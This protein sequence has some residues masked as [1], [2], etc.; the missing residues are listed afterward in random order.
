MR[1]WKEIQKMLRKEFLEIIYI[2]CNMRKNI[3]MPAKV[4]LYKVNQI[5]RTIFTILTLTLY[6]APCPAGTDSDATT[7]TAVKPMAIEAGRLPNPIFTDNSAEVCMNSRYSQHSLNGTAN[8]QQISNILWAAGKA[9]F[10]GTH[11]NIYL[12]TPT[13]T[14]SYDPNGHSLSWYSNEV[15]NDGAFVI[16]YDCQ[17]DFD[18]GV[19]FMPALLASVSLWNSAE[20]AVSSCPKGIGYSKARLIFGVQPVKGLTTKLAVQSSISEGEPGWLPDPCT[21]GDKGLEDVLANLKYVSNFA[22][23]NLT[24]RQISQILWSGYGCTD[25]TASGKAGLTVPS[26]WASYY[27]TRSIYLANENGVFRY[28][29]RNPDT[30]MAS[31]DHR[32]E[33]IDSSSAG[34]G[35]TRPADSRSRLQSTVSGLP[36]APCYVILCLD[37]SSV[38]Q[39]YARLEVGFAAGNML[40][41]ATAID[42]GCYFNAGLTPAEQAGIQVATN[43]PSSH[44]PHAIVSIGPIE[45]TVSISVALQG[46]G[47]SNAGWAVPLI[48]KFFTPGADV[49]TDIPA[50]EFKLTTE[51]S[52]AEKMAV[53]EFTGVAPGIYDITIIGEATLMNIKRSVVI[54][55]PNTSI[56]MGTLLEGDINNDNRIDFKDFVILSTSWL[57][58]KSLP[59]YDI[60]SDFD[61]DGLVNAAD[62]SLLAS[63][64]L[65]SSP[66]EIIP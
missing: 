43:I 23:T 34:R 6:V 25:H 33:Q 31:R 30:N 2:I 26:A 47:R 35:S 12:A 55:A 36:Q 54:S 37:S 61:R 38:S 7:N 19:S 27:L 21:A 28:H 51:K 46:E 59:A 16:F 14:Y 17:H 18:A 22:Q 57:A 8:A 50:Y 44:I 63:N 58:S 41:Q 20:S 3:I 5:K 4:Q 48:V 39:E 11:R 60:K 66:I 9:P 32:I 40:I 1:Q 45:T 52:A 56:E 49:L 24:P 29:N 62:L 42:L 15:R 53:C 10:T 65:G 64:W 13:A